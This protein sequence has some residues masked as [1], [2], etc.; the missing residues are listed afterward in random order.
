MFNTSRWI[1]NLPRSGEVNTPSPKRL[2]ASR[3]HL[4]QVNMLSLEKEI[5]GN[6]HII[7]GDG[8]RILPLLPEL[9]SQPAVRNY[10][11]QNVGGYCGSYIHLFRT[12]AIPFGTRWFQ[13]GCCFWSRLTLYPSCALR[14][15]RNAKVHNF[16]ES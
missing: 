9:P 7:D 10:P 2:N 13:K 14:T 6:P 12:S 4:G 3:S 1:A 8:I 15:R 5:T 11:N 16:A